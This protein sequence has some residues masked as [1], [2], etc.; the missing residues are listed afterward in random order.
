MKL[1]SECNSRFVPSGLTG[2]MHGSVFL[3]KQQKVIRRA[4]LWNDQ[5]TSKECEQ[6]TEAIG[7]EKL[8]S[9]AGNPALTGFQAPKIL[10]LRNNEPEAYA[11]LDKVLLPKDFIRLKLTGEFATDCSD[12]AGTLL[13][14][15]KEKR[16][17]F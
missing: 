8:I 2:Q 17:E 11:K 7:R 9:I 12:A 16:L 3:D 10:W 14:D 4:L 6:I 13:L 5:R 1:G 15:L